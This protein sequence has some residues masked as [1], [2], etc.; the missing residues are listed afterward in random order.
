MFLVCEL[1]IWGGGWKGLTTISCFL[2]K[3]GPN[4]N[5]KFLFG[6]IK[7]TRVWGFVLIRL[8]ARHRTTFFQKL[9]KSDPP[10]SHGINRFTRLLRISRIPECLSDTMGSSEWKRFQEVWFGLQLANLGMMLIVL[11][12]KSTSSMI[13]ALP[14]QRSTTSTW[15]TFSMTLTAVV[16][17]DCRVCL[18]NDLIDLQVWDCVGQ[19]KGRMD[20]RRADVGCLLA[21]GFHPPKR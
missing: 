1:L 11:V 7:S 15:K 18:P 2:Q 9:L 16:E 19:I 21:C 10:R 6:R 13:A 5:S 14:R 12:A 20:V 3:S 17:Q 8:G 4:S